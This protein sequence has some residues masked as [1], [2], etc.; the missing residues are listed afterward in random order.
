MSEIWMTVKLSEIASVKTGPFG[1]LLHGADYKDFG[2]PIVT[3]EHL[4]EAGIVHKNLPLV[5]DKD[6]ERLATYILKEGD[7][8]FSRVGSVDRS[9]IVS[10]Y[11]NGWLFSGRLLRV[12]PNKEQVCY[13][14]LNYF[15]HQETFKHKIRG[16]AVGGTMPCLNTNI[17]ENVH[18][19][20]PPVVEQKRIS[21]ILSVWD[22]A[23]AKTKKLIT[24]KQ[25]LKIVLL[26]KLL[27]SSFCLSEF[28][29]CTL[30]EIA[31]INMG[32]SPSSENY[33]AKKIG[34]PLIQGNAD[35]EN[36]R[37]VPRIWT[38]QVTKTVTADEIIMTVR[39][40]VGEVA[41]TDF[42]AC[43]GR[44][45][46][47]LSPQLGISKNFLY[48]LIIGLEKQW[49]RLSQGSTFTAINSK[50]IKN[51]SVKYPLDKSVQ[52]SI[53]NLGIALEREESLLNQQLQRLQKQKRG[54]M[55]KLLTGKWRVTVEKAD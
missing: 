42:N 54:L 37:F 28:K 15:F 18:I 9:S 39:A 35:I 2:T 51:L 5:S 24:A 17:L 1:S 44:G 29:V 43:I 25:K 23:I 4:S 12:R 40:P 22:E 36:M 45:V 7:I 33:N 27:N 53:G 38:T 34:L 46:C 32:Q 48:F 49:V 47:S 14:F 31:D 16:L 20:L 8:V 50:D 30:G 10:R 3:V 13:Q 6:K 19:T 26:Q 41:I 11:E 55:Q 52:E 21:Q